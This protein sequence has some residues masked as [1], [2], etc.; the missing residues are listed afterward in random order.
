MENQIKRLQLERLHQADNLS[1]IEDCIKDL[2][3]QQVELVTSSE[4][5]RTDTQIKETMIE[6]NIAAMKVK[7]KKVDENLENAK[8]VETYQDRAP[9]NAALIQFLEK[10]IASK[11]KQLEC[12]VCFIVAQA[13]IFC[14]PESHLVCGSCRPKL[15]LCP[16]CRVGYKGQR[17]HRYA[18]MMVKELDT[19][20]E[21]LSQLVVF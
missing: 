16:E 13:P 3:D 2:S 8:N 4:A 11:E 20:R 18:E 9:H 14:C 19:M 10:T 6:N 5:D 15:E 1:G 7:I 17:R 21:E 12:P